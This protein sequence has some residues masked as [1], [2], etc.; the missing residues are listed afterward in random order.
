MRLGV[1]KA[2]LPQALLCADEVF[3]FEPPNAGWSMNEVVSRLKQ[4]ASVSDSIALLL[5]RLAD[6]A[7]P[8]DS[9]VIMSNGAFGGLHQQLVQALTAKWGN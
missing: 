4:P 9:I 2:A 6:S 3:L 8:G 1:H 7:Q 5:Q